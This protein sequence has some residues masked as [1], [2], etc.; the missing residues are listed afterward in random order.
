MA[1]GAGAAATAARRGRRW[2]L[3]VGVVALQENPHVRSRDGS[4]C[5]CQNQHP[6]RAA[7]PARRVAT[8]RP[9]ATST[10]PAARAGAAGRRGCG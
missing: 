6:R 9:L 3:E 5:T 10:R 4:S 7:A 2:R 8:I 1:A